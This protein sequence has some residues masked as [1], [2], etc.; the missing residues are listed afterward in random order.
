MKKLLLILII[1]SV[2]SVLFG[3]G[4]TNNGANFYVSDGAFIHGGNF[5]NITAG[6]NPEIDL[7][8]TI[9]LEGN[10]INN[11]STENI[12][13]NIENYPNGTLILSGTTETN[14][15]G[16]N[17]TFFEN[18]SIVNETKTILVNNC[19]INGLLSLNG[20]LNLNSNRLILN[21][22]NFEI[23]YISGYIFSETIPSDGLGEIE[24]KIGDSQNTFNIPFGSGNT[25]NDLNVSFTPE[26]AGS[27]GGSVVF[28][29]Y[30]TNIE[31]EPLPEN[32]YNL[33]DVIANKTIDRFWKIAPN[34]TVNPD[35]SFTLSYT[36]SDIEG[37]DLTENNLK[38]I[39]F[40]TENEL[41]NDIIF[42]PNINDINN[43]ASIESVSGKDFFNWWTLAE[44]NE[45][46]A[47]FDIPNGITPNDDGFNDTW[48]IDDLPE[49]SQVI[50]YNRWGDEVYKS[51]NYQG[52]WNGGDQPSGAYYYIITLP[53]GNKLSGDI[54]VLK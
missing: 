25:E 50:I 47:E 34:Y 7:N 51:N 43:T 15:A 52:E 37:N 16:S 1:T 45:Q 19:E 22:N 38:L 39:R 21:N 24:M 32:N 18:L 36:D 40:N 48:V 14:I 13:V 46:A 4:I 35:V 26:E 6:E 17:K 31:N 10:W 42:T 5:V 23:E 33:G 41:W 20:I 27:S 53:D 30:P 49:N 28:A 9:E 8:G 12:F 3:Q 29:T 2:S 11:S 54:N 44:V